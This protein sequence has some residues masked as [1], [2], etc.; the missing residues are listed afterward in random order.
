M[1]YRIMKFT[2]LNG[3]K[4]WSIQKEFKHWLTGKPIWK[5]YNSSW[6]IDSEYTRWLSDADKYSSEEYAMKRMNDLL[7]R[8]NE[9]ITDFEVVKILSTNGD[10]KIYEE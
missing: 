5:Y 3:D 10:G 8:D 4:F 9:D 7:K 2:R 6:A 1:K